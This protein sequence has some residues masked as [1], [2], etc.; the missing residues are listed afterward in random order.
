MT[1]VSIFLLL[2]M[3]V[4]T[5]VGV[6]VLFILVPVV[7]RVATAMLRIRHDRARL[8]DKRIEVV[9]AMLQ[10]VSQSQASLAFL[11]MADLGT[12]WNVDQGHQ[13]QQLRIEVPGKN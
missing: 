5:L 9:T 8:S 10:G 3:G 2:V 4:S 1:L 6:A 12:A 7:K 11:S 13:T